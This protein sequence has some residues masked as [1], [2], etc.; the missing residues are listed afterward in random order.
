MIDKAS[1]SFFR[2]RL[3]WIIAALAVAALVVTLIV[4][5][6]G[7]ARPD[8]KDDALAQLSARLDAMEAGQQ[9]AGG[10][11]STAAAPGMG[12][13]RIGPSGPFGGEDGGTSRE[14]KT[15]AQIE[16]DR[17][18]QL[19]E[20]EASFA[21]DTPDPIGGGKTENTLEQTVDGDTM[22][23]TGLKP[24]DVDI[25]CKQNSCRIVGTFD[26]MG[27]AQDWSLFYITAAGGNVLSQTRMVFVPKPDGRTEVRIY[28]N[29]AKG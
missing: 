13:G 11:R 1:S 19:R 17:A 2:D 29:R 18:Q 24:S 10:V 5:R 3:P 7:G 6:G 21:S 4:S 25:A 27:D 12:P 22:K 9:R 23:G 16:A 26:K 14:I 28:S 15:P 20:L 8:P